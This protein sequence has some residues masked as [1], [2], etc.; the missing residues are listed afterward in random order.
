MR[1]TLEP[2]NYAT[3][4]TFSLVATFCHYVLEYNMGDIMTGDINSYWRHYD[5]RQKVLATL[6]LVTKD[7]RTL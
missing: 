2:Y 5:R 6:V 4:V 7:H 1:A 3:K